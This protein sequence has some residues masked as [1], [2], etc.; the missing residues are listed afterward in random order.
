MFKLFLVLSFGGMIFLYQGRPFI[1]NKEYKD[2]IVFS[3]LMVTAVVITCLQILG[4]KIPSPTVPIEI[5]IKAI[6]EVFR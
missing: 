2:L 6:L 4:V 3:F 5:A 1:K